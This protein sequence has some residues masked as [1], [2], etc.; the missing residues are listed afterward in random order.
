M[1]I[2]VMDLKKN[3]IQGKC[4]VPKHCYTNSKHAYIEK[5]FRMLLQKPLAFIY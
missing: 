1:T 2:L 4:R 3:N 5:I